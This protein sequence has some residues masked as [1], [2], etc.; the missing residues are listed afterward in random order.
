MFKH[1]QHK[2]ICTNG[3]ITKAKGV[4]LFIW[5]W[6][7]YVKHNDSAEGLCN[8]PLKIL[9]L[10]SEISNKP[11]LLNI[12]AGTHISVTYFVS[13]PEKTGIYSCVFQASS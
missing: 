11:L 10:I 12:G 1:V 9:L 6:Q 5:I 8:S 4:A 2:Q 7:A 13:N 3:T